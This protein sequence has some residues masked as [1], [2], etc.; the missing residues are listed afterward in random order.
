[1]QTEDTILK[2]LKAGPSS[3]ANLARQI[4]ISR[5]AIHKRLRPLVQKGLVALSGTTRNALYSLA[6]K[7][8]QPPLRTL[9]M[10]HPLPGLDESMVFDAIERDL[11]LK[12]SLPENVAAIARYAFTEMLN[13]AIDHSGAAFCKITVTLTPYDFSFVV[14]DRGVGIFNSIASKFGLPDETRAVEE[15]LKGKTTTMAERHSG[16]GVFFTTKVGD[17]VSLRSHSFELVCDNT[18]EEMILHGRRSTAGTTVAFRI[19]RHSRRS[20]QAVFREYAPEE[21]DYRFER[22]RVHVRLYQRDYVSRSEARRVVTGLDKFTEV[23]LDFSKVNGIE[24]GFAD[25]LFRVFA[26]AHPDVRFDIMD[27]NNAVKAMIRHT[28][29]KSQLSEVD[30][31]LTISSLSSA[32]LPSGT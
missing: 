21:L 14:Q 19:A 17:V 29:D 28:V 30:N 31:K 15:L 25:E 10:R 4:G 16:E 6:S 22:T 13:N 32:T 20:L 5:Q 9:S 1:M 18:R 23:I 3:G 26:T 27:A 12:R 7:D 8:A 2:S 24:Q 11:Q